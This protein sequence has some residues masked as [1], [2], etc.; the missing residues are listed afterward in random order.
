MEEIK[1]RIEIRHNAN[2][3]SFDLLARV[4]PEMVEGYSLR[5]IAE[6]SQEIGRKIASEVFKKNKKKIMAGVDIDIVIKEVEKN[7]LERIKK[8]QV[9]P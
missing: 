2:S 9:K 6:M 8:H 7:L 4:I 1:P 5:A 3:L